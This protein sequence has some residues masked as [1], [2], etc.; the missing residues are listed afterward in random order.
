M[1]FGALGRS[2]LALGV[3]RRVAIDTS[4][5]LGHGIVERQF[6]G[7]LHR[8][9]CHLGVAIAA[10]LCLAG[11]SFLR[12]GRMMAG[13]AR[14]PMGLPLRMTVSGAGLSAAKTRPHITTSRARPNRTANSLE[15]FTSPPREMNDRNK[16][17]DRTNNCGADYR[18]RC[19]A[20]SVT[21]Q[22]RHAHTCAASQDH[23]W[24]CV[25]ARGQGARGGTSN[26]AHVLIPG[27]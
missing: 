4:T 21:K 24:Q 20:N 8:S 13:L 10:G 19:K 12:F 17:N 1:A 16:M 18:G 22:K 23:A 15:I 5:L 6:V 27:C 11:G 14:D 25:G 26:R 9:R 7:G 2:F 3:F